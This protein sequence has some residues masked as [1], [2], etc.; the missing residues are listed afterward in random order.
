MTLRSP[1]KTLLPFFSFFLLVVSQ[2]LAT[3]QAPESGGPSLEAR[4]SPLVNGGVAAG[5]ETSIQIMEMSTGRVVAQRNPDQPVIPASNLK[6]FTTAA[7]YDLLGPSFEF[8]T[9]LSIRGAVDSTGVLNGDVKIT[10]GGDPSIGGRFHDGQSTAVLRKFAEDLKRAGIR[11][12]TGDVILEHGYFDTEYVH[13]TWPEDQLVNWYE[14]PVA[15]LSIQEGTVM[16]RVRPGSP[17]GPAIVEMEPP[18]R[19]MRVLNTARTGGGSGAFIGRKPGTND[20]VVRG[21]VP[22]RSGATEVFVTVMNPL[23]FFA[24]VTHDTLQGNGIRVNGTVKLAETAP[25]SDWRVVSRHQT[26]LAPVTYVINKVS[27]NHYAEQLIKTLGA[28]LK[29]NGSWAVGASVVSEWMTGKLGVPST[30]FL[31]V[32]GSG[33]S[34]FNRASASSFVSVLRYMWDTPHR[35]DFVS[36]MPYSGEKNSRLRRRLNT[37]PYARQV[38]AKTGYIS[39]AIGLSGY[40]HAKS[41]RVYAF[42]FLFNRYRTGVWGVYNLQDDI[43]KTII[44]HG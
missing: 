10:G 26:P 6:L 36:S 28:E 42:S 20:I 23:H 35:R 37:E 22:A 16:V 25:Y 8:K 19:Y 1:R 34:R 2:P 5:S 7:A 12:V 4:L 33:M 3:A 38:Y 21:G 39:G 14:A 40:V 41:G 44:D 31:M 43:L 17:G 32:D 13:P 27:Q 29:G 24:N 30:H 15:A 18:N 11:T 9:T